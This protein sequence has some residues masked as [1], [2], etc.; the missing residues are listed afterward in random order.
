MFFLAQRICVPSFRVQCRNDGLPLYKKMGKNDVNLTRRSNEIRIT[1]NTLSS[2]RFIA[3]PMVLT[4]DS[5]RMQNIVI[6][7]CW[8]QL[9]S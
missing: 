8:W 3:G 9:T 4:S 2:M 6:F 5:D 1:V 7:K